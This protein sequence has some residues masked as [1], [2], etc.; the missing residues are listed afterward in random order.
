M[1]FEHLKLRFTIEEKT[2]LTGT[3]GLLLKFHKSTVLKQLLIYFLLK[4]YV[5][6]VAN[7]M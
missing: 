5:P 4:Q 6:I 3:C 2:K 1:P 7:D